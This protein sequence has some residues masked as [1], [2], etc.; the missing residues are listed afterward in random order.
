MTRQ[1][2]LVKSDQWTKNTPRW[3]VKAYIASIATS[4]GNTSEYSRPLSVCQARLIIIIFFFDTAQ[5]ADNVVCSNL[6]ALWA[7]A[8]TRNLLTTSTSLLLLHP[9]EGTLAAGKTLLRQPRAQRQLG[10]SQCFHGG[11]EKGGKKEKSLP[12]FSRF[13]DGR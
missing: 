1:I 7:L 9:D 6:A 3:E 4:H 13:R 10:Q 8:R 12:R 5:S 2:T 11:E